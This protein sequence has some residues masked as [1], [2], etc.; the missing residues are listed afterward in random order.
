MQLNTK[1][2]MEVLFRPAEE[3]V[4]Y[5]YWLTWLKNLAIQ[6]INEAHLPK[7]IGNKYAAEDF[8]EILII[9]AFLNLSL[10][11]SSDQLNDLLWQEE[12]KHQRLKI[13][14]KIYDGT[15]QRKERKCPNGDQVRKYRSELPN[16]LVKKV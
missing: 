2:G 7:R 1:S 6:C 8:W 15:Y 10:D 4:P 16:Y 3:L 11:E 12:R 5:E 13:T 9:H 14:P